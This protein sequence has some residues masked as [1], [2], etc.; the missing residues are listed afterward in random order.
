MRRDVVVRRTSITVTAGI[1]AALTAVTACGTTRM[2]SAALMN[3]HGISASTLTSEVGN[4]TDSYQASKGSIQ[5]QYP[6]A[7]APQQVLAWLV[8]F[9]IRERMAVRNGITVTPAESQQAQAAIAAQARQSNVTLPDLAVANGLPPDLLPELGRYQAIE[10]ALVRKLDGGTL[11]TSQ[12]AL[13]TLSQQFNMIQCHAA[14]SLTIKINPQFGRMDY[15]QLSVVPA[16]LTLSA[17][18]GGVPTPSPKPQ[19]TPPC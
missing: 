15:S 8:R 1:L 9:R 11:P 7:Q 10:A 2:G 5:L 12:S 14:K 19:P 16:T 4:L 17:P 6:L 13:R 18:P 3:D